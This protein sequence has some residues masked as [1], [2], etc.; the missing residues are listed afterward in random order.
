MKLHGLLLGESLAEDTLA[1]NSTLPTCW[2][3][4]SIFL[5]FESKYVEHIFQFQKFQQEGGI[6]CSFIETKSTSKWEKKIEAGNATSLECR[7]GV[8]EQTSES[9]S[10]KCA[11]V[12]L[13]YTS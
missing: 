2:P 5:W 4:R 13:S 8:Q 10:K 9:F 1:V 12:C 11:F 3:S 6:A 7:L